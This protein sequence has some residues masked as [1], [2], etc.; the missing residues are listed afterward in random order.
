M[1]RQAFLT[2]VRVS[3]KFAYKVLASLAKRLRVLTEQMK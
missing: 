2:L 1:T 3:P